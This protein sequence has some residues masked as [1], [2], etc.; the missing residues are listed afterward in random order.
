MC[1][2]SASVPFA[3][4]IFQLDKEAKDRGYTSSP[5]LRGGPVLV[6]T[7]GALTFTRAHESRSFSI[8]N[9]WK[10]MPEEQ[11]SLGR[12]RAVALPPVHVYGGSLALRSF[13]GKCRLPPR[14]RLLRLSPVAVLLRCLRSCSS[15]LSCHVREF[16][17]VIRVSWERTQGHWNLLPRH[18]S[19]RGD[20]SSGDEPRLSR[21]KT[22]FYPAIFSI[23]IARDIPIFSRICR[24]FVNWG[25]VDF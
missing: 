21:W 23:A 25:I 16:V 3:R 9:R 5:F 1:P 24:E 2:S 10:W 15:S 7:N 8:H 12:L 17:W 19:L 20:P 6:C 18:S 4:R 13:D 11:W 14:W 22:E